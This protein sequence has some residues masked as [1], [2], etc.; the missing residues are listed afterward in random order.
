[1]E[2]KLPVYL[3]EKG[4]RK[5]KKE[6]VTDTLFIS[7]GIVED[8]LGKIDFQDNGDTT[9]QAIKKAIPFIKPI[10]KEIFE[11]LTDEELR[12]CNAMDM[13]VVAKNIIKYCIELLYGV[14]DEKNVT[15]EA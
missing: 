10:L 2:L 7:F 4:K 1:M 15:R 11:G 8:I 6:Y 9:E 14:P 3:S 5:V 12:S 13:I